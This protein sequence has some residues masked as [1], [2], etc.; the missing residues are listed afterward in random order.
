[1]MMKDERPMFCVD[2]VVCVHFCGGF[3]TFDTTTGN[4]SVNCTGY[5]NDNENVDDPNEYYF[6]SR[7]RRLFFDKMII[8]NN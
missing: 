3:L 2:L 6:L 4:V 5:T 7:Q 1:M 8:F